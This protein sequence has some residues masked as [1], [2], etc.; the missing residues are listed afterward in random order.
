ML[1]SFAMFDRLLR[2]QHDHD[3]T[4]WEASGSPNGFFWRP[5][6]A[7]SLL[8]GS[9]ARARLFYHWLVAAPD[10]VCSTPDCSRAL[11]RYRVAT[12]ISIVVVLLYVRYSSSIPATPNQALL[13]AFCEP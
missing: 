9:S 1:Y 3:P 6:K 10:W 13:R 8:G 12:G 11:L 7:S 4:A 5:S 2:W